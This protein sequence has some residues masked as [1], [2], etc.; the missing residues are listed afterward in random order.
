V[1]SPAGQR[2]RP[3]TVDPDIQKAFLPATVTAAGAARRTDLS[4]DATATLVYQ[5]AVLG[6]GVVHIYD[7]RAD[8]S[9][10]DQQV[11]RVEAAAEAWDVHWDEGAMIDLALDDLSPTPLPDEALYASLPRL[12]GRPAAHKEWRQA[13]DDFIYRTSELRLWACRPLDLYSRPAEPK[14]AF[15]RRCT[16]EIERQI[17][18]ELEEARPKFE[19]KIHRVQARIRRET[20]EL[21]EDRAELEERRREELLSGA[22]TMLNLL[23]RRRRS[24]A[25]S[26]VSR[27]RRYVKKARS[28]VDESQTALD[29]YE[30]QLDDLREEW[31]AA[32]TRIVTSWRAALDEIEPYPVRPRRRDVEVRFCGLAWFPFW[33]FDDDGEQ[34]RLPAYV[35][36]A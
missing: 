17:G 8:V 32:E 24:R 22:E 3:P 28:D 16:A 31:E 10:T 34:L 14:S 11:W 35:P 18:L 9:L 6:V 2:S 33:A 27:Q 19:R 7:D 12:L 29:I 20:L 21:E 26:Q 4:P 25:L 30:E 36:Q 5:P 1:P 13:F 23:S 15:L